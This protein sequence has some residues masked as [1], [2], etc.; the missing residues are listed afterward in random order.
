MYW[1]VVYVEGV[2][3]CFAWVGGFIFILFLD[4]LVGVCVWVSMCECEVACRR[5]SCFYFIGSGMTYVENF[6]G[7]SIVYLYCLCM[8][9]LSFCGFAYLLFLCVGSYVLLVSESC[10]SWVWCVIS[11]V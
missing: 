5:E 4:I 6:F 3:L 9:T 11:C 7:G 8:Y 10:F 2:S 1:C